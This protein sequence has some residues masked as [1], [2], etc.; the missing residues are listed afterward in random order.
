MGIASL[1][2]ALYWVILPKSPTILDFESGMGDVTLDECAGIDANIPDNNQVLN[3][4]TSVVSSTS[5]K[6]AYVRSWSF[7]APPEERKVKLADLKKPSMNLKV[8]VSR[9]LARSWS[10]TKTTRSP[11]PQPNSPAKDFVSL[12][13][14]SEETVQKVEEILNSP[15]L[16]SIDEYEI[17]VDNSSSDSVPEKKP[18]PKPKPLVKTFVKASVSIEEHWLPLSN[19]DRVVNPTFSS[20]IHYYDN[21]INENRSFVDVI[22]FLKETLSKTLVDFYPLAGRLTLREDGKVDLYCNNEGAIWIEATVPSELKDVGG[23]RA[24]HLLSGFDVAK[25]GAGPL[26]IPDQL[27]PMPVLIIQVTKFL[28][29][30][31]AIA[32]SWHHTVADGFSGTHFLRS[33]SEVALGKVVSLKPEHNRIILNARDPPNPTLVNGYSTKTLEEICG[34]GAKVSTDEPATLEKFDLSKENVA[35][36][37]KQANLEPP[38]FTPRPYTS[39]ESV[40]GH[41]WRQMTKARASA[42]SYGAEQAR[43]QTTKFFMFVDGRKR[44]RL[45]AGYFGNVVCSACA[46][47]KEA[48]ILTNPLNYAAS[49]IRIAT[50]NITEEYFRSLIDWVELQGVASSKSEHVNSLGHD[51]AATFWTFF[52]LYDIEFGW[53]RP[54]FAARNSP[55][56]PLIDGI[57]MMPNA[58]GQGMVALLNLHSDRMSKLQKQVS[59]STVFRTQV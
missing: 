32:T 16:P 27:T 10:F 35:E 41:L 23:L 58:E 5:P 59:F 28:C 1:L 52:P 50:R 53:G 11:L 49:L 57:A 8:D 4:D 37:K 6:T 21:V 17:A 48:D 26:F 15:I 19:L 14:E 38:P 34:D 46:V 33:W 56:R 31:I 40:S 42:N 9:A 22:S 29:G 47:A 25:L 18:L 36:L 20:V 55:P 30:T 43:D 12:E 3:P 44:L 45:P 13:G 7:N 51:V 24:N 39:A 54:K 2:E